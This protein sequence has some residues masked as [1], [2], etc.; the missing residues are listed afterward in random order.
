MDI[1]PAIDLKNG[2]CV[3]LTQGDFATAT[4]YQFNP[5][6]QAQSFAGAGADWLHMVDLDGARIGEM[7]QFD[8]IAEVARQV[9]LKIQAGGGVRDAATIEKLLGAG[10]ERVVIGSL[11]VKDLPLVKEWLRRFGPERLVLAFDIRDVSGEPE[12]LTHGWQSSSSQSLWDI[13]QDYTDSGLKTILCTDVS[14]DGMLEG[15]N[16]ALYKTLRQRYPALDVLASGGISGLDDLTRLAACGV[17][18]V[19]VGKAIYERRVDLAAA[20]RQVKNAC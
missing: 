7:Q 19:I 16:H 9:P 14:R 13:L 17:A 1:F 11:A 10:V 3:R 6:A 8:L 4:I 15:T 20:I 5:V 18:G 2:A 12:I